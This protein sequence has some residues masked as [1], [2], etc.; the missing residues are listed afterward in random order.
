MLLPL[1]GGRDIVQRHDVEC[2]G[3]V[4][5]LDERSGLWEMYFTGYIVQ[6]DDVCYLL[7]H[8]MKKHLMDCVGWSVSN[9]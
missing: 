2:K 7:N 8:F 6:T 4:S 5:L 3:V 1:T 9:C